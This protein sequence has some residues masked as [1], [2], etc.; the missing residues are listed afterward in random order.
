MHSPRGLAH[1]CVF[2]VALPLMKRQVRNLFGVIMFP[3]A[4]KTRSDCV[5]VEQ[6]DTFSQL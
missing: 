4:V 2:I 3:V 5:L 1:I 6:I